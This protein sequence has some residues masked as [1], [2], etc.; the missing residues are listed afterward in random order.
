[1]KTLITENS[2]VMDGSTPSQRAAEAQVESYLKDLAGWRENSYDLTAD[3]GKIT[4]RPGAL[5]S[6]D[7]LR[8]GRRGPV[9]H[10]DA[11]PILLRRRK[12]AAK[13]PRRCKTASPPT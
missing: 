2:F 13:P 3:M 8:H 12:S 11:L 10:K 9:H 7:N 6:G 1:M 5:H 4:Q